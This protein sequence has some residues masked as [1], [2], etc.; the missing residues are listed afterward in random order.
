MPRTV[1]I[2]QARMGSSRLPGKVLLDIGG[3]PMLQHVVERTRTSELVQEVVV[4]TTTDEGD[5]VVAEFCSATGTPCFRGSAHD[6]LDRYYQAARLHGAE[7]VV[8][9]TGDCPL[10]DPGLIDVT[11]GLVAEAW[12]LTDGYVDFACN[13]L[14][15]PFS[16]S[17]PIGLDVEACAFAVLERAWKEAEQ[18]FQREHVMPYLYENVDLRLEN[19]PHHKDHW[20]SGTE[21]YLLATGTSPRGFRIAQLHHDPDYGA[22]RW[23]VDTPED[24]AFAREVF[25]RLESKRDFGWLD[26][27]QLVDQDP[28]LLELND[29][30]HHK[31]VHDVDERPGGDLRG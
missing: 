19:L 8:R 24:L 9:I 3:K 29:R 1:A 20:P 6:V 17:L 4:A 23:T 21:K 14:P 18:P 5:R 12:S 15:P 13:R 22:M 26:L 27:I 10:I 25:S 2:I 11:T 30:V 16:R 28:A 7:V 31:T